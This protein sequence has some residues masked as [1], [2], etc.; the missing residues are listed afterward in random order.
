MSLE[1]AP[2]EAA[3]PVVLRILTEDRVNPVNLPAAEKTAV[4]VP[5][6]TAEMEYR[7]V[8][9]ESRMMRMEMERL[10]VT[11]VV[12]AVVSKMTDPPK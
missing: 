12:K 9:D 6:A 4:E 3:C 10:A 1:A 5:V 8:V 7:I 2:V 11:D